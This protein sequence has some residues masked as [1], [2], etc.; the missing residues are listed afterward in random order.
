[1]SHAFLQRISGESQ[2]TSLTLGPLAQG[3]WMKIRHIETTNHEFSIV[4]E[5][6]LVNSLDNFDT[7]G[8][9]SPSHSRSP[10]HSPNY[11]QASS[12][13][14]YAVAPGPGLPPE[15]SRSPRSQSRAR[16]AA[17]TSAGWRLEW[18]GTLRTTA[19]HQA[20]PVEGFPASCSCHVQCAG[21]SPR[22]NHIY[23]QSDVRL[24]AQPK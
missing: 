15:A 17:A 24:L 2:K 3:Q 14:A 22:P 19:L 7:K 1:M 12:S 21:R 11:V 6:S 18:S 16:C 8:S 4:P 10:S 23:E 5:I 9:C 20:G 13:P